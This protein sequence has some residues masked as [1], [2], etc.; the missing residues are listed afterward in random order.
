MTSRHVDRCVAPHLF[1]LHED[2]LISSQLTTGLQPRRSFAEAMKITQWGRVRAAGLLRGDETRT[3]R[4][5]RLGALQHP[6]L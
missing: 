2:N 5:T 3:S 1:F 6:S 4:S